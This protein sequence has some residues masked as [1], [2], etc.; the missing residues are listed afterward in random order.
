VHYAALWTSGSDAQKASFAK[1]EVTVWVQDV[2]GPNR[3]L[4]LAA[5]KAR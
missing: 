1:L 5:A 4:M 3:T 2:T